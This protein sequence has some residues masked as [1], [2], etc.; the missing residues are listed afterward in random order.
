MRVNVLKFRYFRYLPLGFVAICPSST[1]SDGRGSLFWG[2]P[3]TRRLY[4][5]T[6]DCMKTWASLVAKASLTTCNYNHRE[7]SKHQSHASL[8]EGQR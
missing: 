7:C 8:L 3:K 2:S 1:E 5:T 6:A 4:N